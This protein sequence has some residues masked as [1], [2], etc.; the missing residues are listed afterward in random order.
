[1]R[2]S[3]AI[4]GVLL[5]LILLSGCGGVAGG[6]SGS[7]A[8][9]TAS[10]APAEEPPS[11]PTYSIAGSS[12]PR[13]VIRGFY[14]ALSNRDYL[15]AWS[16]LSA[17]L[18]RQVGGYD[19]WLATYKST[20]LV[21]PTGMTV[22]SR[23]PNRASATLT[24][25]SVDKNTCGHR[26]RHNFF[27]SWALRRDHGRWTASNIH[28]EATALQPP[29]AASDTCRKATGT[30]NP[31]ASATP[32]DT[33]SSDQNAPAKS[34]VG[35]VCYPKVHLAAVQL[36]AVDLP[37]TTLPAFTFNGHRYPARYLPGQHIPGSIIPATTIPGGCFDA[38]A[39]FAPAA[40]TV[41]VTGYDRLDRDFSGPLSD[42]YWGANSEVSAPDPTAA[43]FGDLNA[44]GFPKNQYVRPYVRRDG[45]A[46]SGYWRNSPSDGLPTCR[47]ISC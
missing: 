26:V 42:R 21:R 10:A 25:R 37:A 39:S 11:A 35:R 23:G 24:L 15:A 13:A 36:P 1:V 46:V 38:P 40:T 22:T 33:P 32:A 43:G 6:Q 17:D 3:T 29:V 19:A 47:V 7:A 28:K 30:S 12:G 27:S 16:R 20:E 8:A 31:K 18:R 41:R 4:L 2:A 44:A 45:T 9:K 34:H 5:V 14:G